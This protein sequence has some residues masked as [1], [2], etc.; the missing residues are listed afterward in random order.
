MLSE[1][2]LVSQ[3]EHAM[4]HGR[5]DT[6]EHFGRQLAALDEAKAAGP[7]LAGAAVWY[8]SAGY[9]VFPCLPA[10]SVGIDGRPA[11][12]RP[13][14]RTGC[15]GATTDTARVQGWWTENPDYNIG[16]A[17]G[18]QFDVIDID[19]LA[20]LKSWLDLAGAPQVTGVVKT[21]RPGG[22][23]L[24]LPV[25]GRGNRAGMAPGIDYR[26]VG[27]YVLGPPSRV[28]TPEYTGG[29]RWHRPLAS[30][31]FSWPAQ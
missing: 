5:W 10:G 18:H 22:W 14:I 12:K 16:L 29:Y 11:C 25:T 15:H 28:I 24:Y 30:E 26:G 31:P 9:P 8:A 3:I 13:A 20:G 7:T 1:E 19:G 27:G 6:A 21:P 23:H 2:R 17:T 4:S